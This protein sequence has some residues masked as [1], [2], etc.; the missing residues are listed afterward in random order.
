MD[1]IK[2]IQEDGS[3]ILVPV[4]TGEVAEIMPKLISDGCNLISIK[5]I[6]EQ[7]IYAFESGDEELATIWND[8]SYISGDGFVENSKGDVK[9][10]L[11]SGNLRTISLESKLNNSGFLDL[12]SP[13]N[14]GLERFDDLPSKTD[15]GVKLYFSEKEFGKFANRILNVKPV[16]NFVWLAALRGDKT[17]LKR[18][19]KYVSSSLNHYD[20]NI[21]NV[22]V[23]NFRSTGYESE[24]FLGIRGLFN[25]GGEGGF[26]SCSL[27][28][29]YGGKLIG[30]PL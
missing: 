4:Y 14:K 16:D 30:I 26:S 10:N 9:I 21:M 22:Q 2:F 28:A 27:Y 24:N 18:C 6:I 19:I 17:L 3:S 25:Y 15:D 5:Q 13:I 23:T 1:E 7:K 12:E 11:D 20:T 8:S 29:G